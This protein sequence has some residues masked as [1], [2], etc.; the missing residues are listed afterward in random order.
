MKITRTSAFTG[1][2]HTLEINVTENQMFMYLY[3]NANIQ[4]A[5]P[6]LS[7]DDREF[8]KTGVT[9]EEWD[10]AFKNN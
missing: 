3:L 6:N 10:S 7:P 4:D 8:I 1:K 9:K 5:F 2:L